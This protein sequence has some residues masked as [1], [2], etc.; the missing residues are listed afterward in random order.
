MALGPRFQS[1]PRVWPSLSPVIWTH[2]ASWAR[3]EVILLIQKSLSTSHPFSISPGE[4]TNPRYPFNMSDVLDLKHGASG[5]RDQWWMPPVDT[6]EVS[7]ENIWQRPNS[8]TKLGG[9]MT[10]VAKNKNSPQI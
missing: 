8:G 4:V 1:S 7:V 2:L 3:P 10:T 6:R 5:F 9:N